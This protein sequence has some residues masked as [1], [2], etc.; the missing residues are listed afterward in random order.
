MGLGPTGVGG[1]LISAGVAWCDGIEDRVSSHL[2][3]SRREK[4]TTVK[5]EGRD[6]GHKD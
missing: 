4:F 2:D 1:C 3:G 5:K 6:E